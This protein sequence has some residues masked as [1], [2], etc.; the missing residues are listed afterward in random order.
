M[1]SLAVVKCKEP[2][3]WLSSSTIWPLPTWSKSLSLHYL[4]G[5]VGCED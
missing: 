3:L 5:E 1:T 4:I 2:E